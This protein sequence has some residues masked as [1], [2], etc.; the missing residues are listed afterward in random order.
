MSTLLK[1][2]VG[3]YHS[4]VS[5]PTHRHFVPLYVRWVWLALK[6]SCDI[7]L[8]AEELRW[9]TILC[10][11]PDVRIKLELAANPKLL[12]VESCCS[13]SDGHTLSRSAARNH[14]RLQHLEG[15]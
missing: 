8:N 14:P 9:L 1:G 11:I 5:L 6:R 4:S 13:E 3:M 2:N 10:D 12:C 7:F 15:T